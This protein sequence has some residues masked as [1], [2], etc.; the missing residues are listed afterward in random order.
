MKK[1]YR[2]ILLLLLL[3]S[4]LSCSAPSGP[5]V[6]TTTGDGKIDSISQV[7]L[8]LSLFDHI[9]SNVSESVSAIGIGSKSVSGRSLDMDN[10]SK[11]ILLKTE[12]DIDNPESVEFEVSEEFQ[13][14]F[15]NFYSPGTRLSLDDMS[16]TVDKLYV[17]G[18]YT[19]IS[20]ISLDIKALLSA[21]QTHIFGT[22]GHKVYEGKMEFETGEVIHTLEYS[23][24]D[25][26]DYLSIKYTS[27]NGFEK[28]EYDEQLSF[29]S[30][31]IC[32]EVSDEGDYIKKYDTY[33]YSSSFFR[34]SFVIDNNTGLVYPILGLDL[35]VQHGI[36]YEKKLGPVAIVKGEKGLSFVQLINNSD[37]YVYDIMCDKHGQY[38]ILNDLIDEVVQEDG[39]TV[40]YYTKNS[41][42]IQLEDRRMMH[43][44]FGQSGQRPFYTDPIKAVHIIGQNLTEE[45]LEYV[46]G[47]LKGGTVREE[48]EVPYSLREF[49]K[50]NGRSFSKIGLGTDLEFSSIDGEYLY[51]FYVADASKAEFCKINL[52]SRE[53]C[54][55]VYKS[56]SRE[57]Y[58]GSPDASTLL[59][60]SRAASE[61]NKYSIYSVHPYERDEYKQHYYNYILKPD[62]EV[63]LDPSYEEFKEKYYKGYR[64]ANTYRYTP[65]EFRQ[66]YQID[67]EGTEDIVEGWWNI[68]GATYE[69]EG[70]YSESLKNAA[71]YYVWKDGYSDKTFDDMYYHYIYMEDG[72]VKSDL[73]NHSVL[74]NVAVNNINWN[75]IDFLDYE[76]PVVSAK[77]TNKYRLYFDKETGDYSADLSSSVLA[78]RKKIILQPII[79]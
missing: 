54:F 53:C 72:I 47:F 26:D 45:S 10:Y 11:Y 58:Y 32:S 44:D 30:G 14:L 59:V 62:G 9:E 75:A 56:S 5:S 77:G 61:N 36:A 51:G 8:D 2:Y 17:M 43:I 29:R 78:I 50:A 48:K 63:V 15:G 27:D 76:F 25:N 74:E 18:D 4:M 55:I 24:D 52:A 65:N 79:R 42:Y 70:I 28:K 22:S 41:E 34:K 23:Y 38:F 64:K 33:G 66:K 19:L 3:G 39:I 20:F 13:D 6:M 31:E 37:I 69:I 46:G 7:M 57:E 35:S 16:G 1:N 67:L 40:V 71:F 49:N 60:V 12:S 68:E 73:T 21:E